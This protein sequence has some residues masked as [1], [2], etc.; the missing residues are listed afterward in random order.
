MREVA[1]FDPPSALY[2]GQDGLD[3]Y[4]RIARAVEAYLNPAGA[5]MMEFG[6]GQQEAILNIFHRPMEFFRDLNGICRAVLIHY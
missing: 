3:F 4:R 1:A 2:A 6:I 5:L